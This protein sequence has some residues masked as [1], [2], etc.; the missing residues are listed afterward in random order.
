MG[1]G[2]KRIGR[3]LARFPP[4]QGRWPKA[5]WTR[6]GPISNEPGPLAHNERLD[7][8]HPRSDAVNPRSTPSMSR[9]AR[10]LVAAGLAVA[11]ATASAD[12]RLPL[13]LVADVPLGGNATRLDYLSF[14]P[15]RHLLYIAHL[16]DGAVIVFDTQARRVLDRIDGVAKA[17]G[18]LALPERGAAYASA[19]GTDEVVAIDAETRRIAA[20]MPGGRCPD[21]MADAPAGPNAYVADQS[22]CAETA[23]DA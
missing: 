8:G 1:A 15:S 9:A 5:D 22:A 18:V 17:H 11:S 12:T 13:E 10:L 23:S 21:G 14:D 20:R 2:P 3:A 19:T 7:L 16:G 4:S 6:P